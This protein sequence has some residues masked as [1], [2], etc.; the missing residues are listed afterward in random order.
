MKIVIVAPVFW[1]A[2]IY[3]GPVYT[4]TALAKALSAHG[5]DITVLTGN[6]GNSGK[7]DAVCGKPQ[8]FFGARLIYLN[9]H[10]TPPY[11]PLED[12]DEYLT[13]E[14]KNADILHISS[15]LTR[16][17]WQALRWATRNQ[18]PYAVTTRGHLIR[19]H[20]WKDYKKRVVVKIFLERYLRAAAFLQATSTL[21]AHALQS[22]GFQNVEVV[23]HGVE[24]PDTFETR[25]TARLGWGVGEDEVAIIALG[26][27]HPVKGLEL[28]FKAIGRLS[29]PGLKPKLLIA[30]GGDGAY[31]Q[32]LEELAAQEDI[33]SQCQFV[34]QVEGAK[35]WSLLRASDLFVHLSTGE[36]FGLAIGEA[37]GAGLPVL[38][39]DKC[40][41]EEISDLGF[42]I[43]IPR[44]L[45]T[46]VASLKQLLSDKHELKLMGK[47]A[48]SW[49]QRE[50]NW[51]RIAD[52]LTYL[53]GQT[54]TNIPEGHLR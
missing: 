8:D 1:P 42:G 18:I 30:G 20:W 50:F 10:R 14:A 11:G 17:A 12:L 13:R 26:R 22:Y 49:V 21:E 3:G 28:L 15:T 52:E 6:L 32:S 38:I 24:L 31:V 48:S 4:M 54:R 29:K 23:P 51:A 34:G 7:I 46:V 25:E 27:L 35:K 41:W 36:S 44:E 39:G 47:K 9:Q 5:E 53:Y 33:V 16:T 19:R 40:G 37:L 45:D 43:R 2:T